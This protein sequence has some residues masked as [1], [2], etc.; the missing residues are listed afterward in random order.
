MPSEVRQKKYRKI[1]EGP[2]MFNFWAS[3]PG[4]RGWSRL[5][6]PGSARAYLD[7]PLHIKHYPWT[8]STAEFCVQLMATSPWVGSLSLVEFHSIDS[9]LK[10][11][12]M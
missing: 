7:T 12:K 8:P 1:I 9:Y 6:P 4:V 10:L 11:R 5:L 2:K 3:K